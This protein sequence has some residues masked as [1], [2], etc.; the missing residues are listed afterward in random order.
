MISFLSFEILPTPLMLSL[1]PHDTD[2]AKSYKLSIYMSASIQGTAACW[3]QN[4][5]KVRRGLMA[6][7]F[8]YFKQLIYSVH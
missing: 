3:I 6:K 2:E 1:S 7:P 4:H 8:L 5:F